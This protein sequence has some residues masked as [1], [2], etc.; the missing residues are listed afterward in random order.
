M[1]SEKWIETKLLCNK[2]RE[3]QPTEGLEKCI[4][5]CMCTLVMK[6]LVMLSGLS[7][8]G[9]GGPSSCSPS[10]FSKLYRK[11]GFKMCCSTYETRTKQKNFQILL[12]KRNSTSLR[13]SFTLSARGFTVF[14]LLCQ[15]HNGRFP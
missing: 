14:A 13:P 12:Q 8:S 9:L 10:P 4:Y 1:K 5:T 15:Y 7:P 2:R 11:A 6:T 3:N